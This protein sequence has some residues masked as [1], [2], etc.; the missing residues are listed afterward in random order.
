MTM[1]GFHYPLNYMIN[2][3]A[4]LNRNGQVDAAASQKCDISEVMPGHQQI[5]CSPAT[6]WPGRVLP[7]AQAKDISV[8][9]NQMT[10]FVSSV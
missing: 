9:D 5:S 8:H 4:I 3:M 7:L 2:K 10:A 1:I 6:I